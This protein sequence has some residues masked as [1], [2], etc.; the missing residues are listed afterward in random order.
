MSVGLWET[1]RD[2]CQRCNLETAWRLVERSRGAERMAFG[3]AWALRSSIPVDQ[4]NYLWVVEP[5]VDAARLITEARAF[6]AYRPWKLVC[7]E[8]RAGPLASALEGTTMT[9]RRG[10]PGMIL[11]EL[12]SATPSMQGLEVRVADTPK[13]YHDFLR[14]ASRGFSIP[15]FGLRAVLPRGPSTDGPGP[16]LRYLVGYASG[17]PVA[18]A[19]IGVSEGV[20]V[21][22]FVSSLPAARRH[23][24]GRM[25]TSAALSLGRELGGEI[26]FLQASEMGESVYAKMGF[27]TVADFPEW[28]QGL[29]GYGKLRAYG[30][31]FRLMLG[32]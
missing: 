31:M 16:L 18:T 2:R 3:S 19:G 23:G 7:E 5:P 9:H 8:A 29:T 27:V 15:L 22:H 4:T 10:S 11:K 28:L 20:V 21:V 6:F 32:V 13:S 17:R 12:P 1:W 26:G 24:Y 30:G 25:M 14:T